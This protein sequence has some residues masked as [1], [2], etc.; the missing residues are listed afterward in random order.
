MVAS[1][2]L[3]VL[4]AV[5]AFYA[6]QKPANTTPRLTVLQ[7]A[8]PTLSAP[9]LTAN[10]DGVPEVGVVAEASPEIITINLD[11]AV[12]DISDSEIGAAELN[13]TTP[14]SENE[15]GEFAPSRTEGTSIGPIY[16]STDIS[17]NYQAIDPGNGF[18]TGYFTLYAT[19]DYASME[20]GTNWSWVWK[21][22]GQVIEGGE[23]LWSYG[24]DGPG[25]V[26]LSPE[27]GFQLGDH[28]LEVWVE[29]KLMSQSSFSI[30]EGVSASN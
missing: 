24:S 9:S 25:Y 7:N 27:E 4:T 23:Q 8:K 29:E 10:D 5:A 20:E 13:V 15:S 18:T 16:F 2:L 22:N 1:A 28:S 17:A 6:W 26:Y 30:L 14:D 19:F 12:E 21:R 11:S 3:S